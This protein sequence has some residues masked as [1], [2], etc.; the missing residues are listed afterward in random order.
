[1]SEIEKNHGLKNKKNWVVRERMGF[2]PVK[3][4]LGLDDWSFGGGDWSMVSKISKQ[5]WKLVT[6]ILGIDPLKVG[7]DPWERY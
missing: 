3:Y 6:G 1:M 7:I 5:L 4:V 2:F